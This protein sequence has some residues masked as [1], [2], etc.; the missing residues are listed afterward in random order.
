MPEA[1]KPV[2]RRN[3]IKYAG[4][5]VV[6]AAA[7]GGGYYYS[8]QR[9][10][11]PTATTPSGPSGEPVKIAVPAPLSGPYAYYGNELME[12]IREGVLDVNA[13][14]GVLGRPVETYVR[15][16]ELTPAV[17]TRRM[18]E[19]I[20]TEKVAF[21]VGEIGSQNNFAINEISKR[22]KIHF[23]V[24]N[25]TETTM[26]T[27]DVLSPY[28]SFPMT[29]NQTAAYANMATTIAKVGP[30]H[31]TLAVDYVWGHEQETM[32]KEALKVFNGEWIGGERF[33]WG[34]PISQPC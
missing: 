4:A 14:G 17:A 27:K 19:L 31:Y 7:I 21:I 33:P 9:P 15:D 5:A 6:A 24:G 28:T 34:Q 11:T 3:F 25:Q 10:P 13:A 18:T 26:H 20:E 8:T 12:G 16:T 22:E 30:K 1:K 2:D 29:V 32:T 23:M